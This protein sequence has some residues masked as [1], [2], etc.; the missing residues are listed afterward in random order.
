MTNLGPCSTFLVRH[1]WLSLRGAVSEELTRHDLSVAQFASLLMLE[2]KP[3][4]TVADVAR[5]VSTARQSANEML[6]GLETAGLVERRPH[7]SDRRSQQVFLTDAGRQ[8]LTEALPSVQAVEARL[9]AGFTAEE[10]AV[11][12]AWLHR[13]TEPAPAGEEISTL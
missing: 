1:A 7:P 3:G 5:E 2:E 11:V 9:S 10:L 8:R 6:A 13:M 12:N 4:L